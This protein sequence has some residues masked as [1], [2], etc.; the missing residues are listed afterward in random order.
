MRAMLRKAHAAPGLDTDPSQR[1]TG[2][3]MGKA[4]ESPRQFVVIGSTTTAR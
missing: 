4:G 3:S 1:G 2:V